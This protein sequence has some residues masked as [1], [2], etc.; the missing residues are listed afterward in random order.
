MTVVFQAVDDDGAGVPDQK[1]ELVLT[2]MTRLRF[3]E[4]EGTNRQVLRTQRKSLSD[5]VRLDGAL[6]VDLVVP[7][8]ALPGAASLVASLEGPK[9]D[10]PK[11][12]WVTFDIEIGGSGGMGGVGG[13]AGAS[14]AGATGG[15]GA[16]GG[17]GAAGGADGGTAGSVV[18]GGQ[19][20]GGVSG[21]GGDPGAAAAA[22]I[23]QVAG[24][25]DVQ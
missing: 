15:M 25:A 18:G 14:G 1:V 9:A 4:A 12:R 5:G 11:T 22:G 10:Q 3:S 7:Q 6:A 19:S 13:V 2:D 20:G 21:A 23:F 16:F 17:V 24:G 8:D